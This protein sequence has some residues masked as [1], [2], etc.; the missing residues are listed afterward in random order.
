MI[1]AINKIKKSNKGS[2]RISMHA[3]LLLPRRVE[4]TVERVAKCVEYF[5]LAC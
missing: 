2:R 5:C 3:L 1:D 4:V